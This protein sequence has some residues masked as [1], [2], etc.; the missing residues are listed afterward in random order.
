M[1]TSRVARLKAQA[2]LQVTVESCR[3]QGGVGGM[4]HMTDLVPR[5]QKMLKG[6]LPSVIYHRV[7]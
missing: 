2:D 5:A 4:W 6:H 3:V 1:K 7:H